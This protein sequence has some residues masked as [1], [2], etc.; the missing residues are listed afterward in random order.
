MLQK[1]NKCVWPN[2]SQT[3]AEY[4]AVWGFQG[5]CLFYS[6]NTERLSTPGGAAEAACRHAKQAPGKRLMLPLSMS[7]GGA[8]KMVIGGHVF[9]DPCLH[10]GGRCEY[11]AVDEV[12]K[13]DWLE[14][15]C[16]RSLLH[17]LRRPIPIRS[18]EDA[19][20]NLIV[21]LSGG[22]THT[23]IPHID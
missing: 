9:H 8:E 7:A 1:K 17:C 15:T 12:S 21:F 20:I 18:K 16:M 19:S 11:L 6:L 10:L 23:I 4:T 3:A 14:H 5:Q 13:L 2:G 22:V